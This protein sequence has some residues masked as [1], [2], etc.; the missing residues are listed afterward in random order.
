MNRSAWNR[1]AV[2]MAAIALPIGLQAQTARPEAHTVRP[3]DTLWD[4]SRQYLGDPLLWPEIYRLNTNVVEDPHWIYPGEV[5]RLAAGAD[6]SAVPGADTPPP[7]VEADNSMAA[8]EPAPADEAAMADQP[9][10][11]GLAE[12]QIGDVVLDEEPSSSRDDVDLTPL[13]GRSKRITS[14]GPSLELS[15][16]QAYRPIRRSE[17]FSS[18]FLSEGRAL[19]LGRV[20]GRVTPLQIEAMTIASPAM[21][22]TQVAVVPPA[23]AQ[24]QVG[25]TLLTVVR[26]RAIDGYG[27]VII[28]TGL[29]R[30][31]DNS[32]PEVLAEVLS[33]YGPIRNGQQVLPAERFVDPGNSRAVPISDGVTGAVVGQRDQQPLTGPQDVLFLNR[34]RADGVALGDVFELRQ[35]PRNRPEAAATIDEP[36]AT[37]QVVHVSERTSTARVVRVVQPDVSAGTEARQVAKLPS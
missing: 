34:G 9:A 4:L 13:V 8:A 6:I 36:M 32:R 11:A 14:S 18:G 20:L 37:V 17:F 16:A 21:P 24:Y 15:L 10:A 35:R 22:H 3:G 19:P 5:L 25:D 2:L 12:P 7:A 33:I 26:A 30:V 1:L 23:G 28:P 27:D 31:V 29:L